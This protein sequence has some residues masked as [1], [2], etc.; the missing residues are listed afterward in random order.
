MAEV[1]VERGTQDLGRERKHRVHL[2]VIPTIMA[3]MADLNGFQE[4]LKTILNSQRLSVSALAR[5]VGVNRTTA[6]RWL[7]EHHLP[8]EPLTFVALKLWA[9]EIRREE[10]KKQ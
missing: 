10:R 9:G 5:S 7:W 3:G 1:K 8:R 6:S 4:D 2:V